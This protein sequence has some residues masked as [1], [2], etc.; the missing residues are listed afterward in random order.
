MRDKAKFE[1][2]PFAIP[3]P[4]LT[5]P[6]L[7]KFVVAVDEDKAKRMTANEVIVKRI[8]DLWRSRVGGTRGVVD[9]RRVVAVDDGSSASIV[10]MRVKN[11]S[12]SRDTWDVIWVAREISREFPDDVIVSI[13][14][15]LHDEEEEEATEE[16]QE[17]NLKEMSEKMRKAL[18]ENNEEGDEEYDEELGNVLLVEAADRLPAWIEPETCYGRCFLR[19]GHLHLVPPRLLPEPDSHRTRNDALL[20]AVALLKSRCAEEETSSTRADSPLERAAFARCDRPWDEEEEEDGFDVDKFF[21]VLTMT[22]TT[23]D[24]A[25][26]N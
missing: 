21:A 7:I 11:S 13:D 22:T 23:G 24:D 18:E 26:G 17:E 12:F 8:C 16:T 1:S 4:T 10:S 19:G 6:L 2:L 15:E 5:T 3:T 20:A 9:E 14:E 25:G